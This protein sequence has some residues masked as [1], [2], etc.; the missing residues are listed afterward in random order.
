[1]DDDKGVDK[2]DLHF[3]DCVVQNEQKADGNIVLS[4][5]EAALHALR[6][7]FPHVTKLIVQSDNA[8]NLAGKQTKL[9]LPYVC[10]AAGLRLVAYYHNEA[11]SGKDVCDT[12]FSHQQSQVEAYL[13]QGNCGRKL[14]TPKQLAVALMEK[15]LSNTTVLL[16]KPDFKAPY[17][18]KVIPAISGIS[19]YYAAQ[20]ATT[21]GQQ[22]IKFYMYNCLGQKVPS[23]CVPIPSCHA[24]SLIN[25]MGE[26]GINFTGVAVLLNSFSES[27]GVQVRKDKGRYKKR[28]KGISQSQMQR[29]QKQHEDEEALKRIQ[30]VY[31]Q[32]TVCLY[33]FKSQLLLAKHVCSEVMDT[34]MYSVLQC[35]MLT[36]FWPQWTSLFLVL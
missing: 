26:E 8:K 11:Q 34:K 9:L 10:S 16:V 35:G 4:C 1:M 19:E 7:R 22:H 27:T 29:V 23:A 2:V 13:V 12:H 6:Q 3:I 20:Y 30:A 33:H 25:A 28:T 17:R 36:L 5:L 14:S 21:D 32:C 24:T 31:P 15:S 18:S